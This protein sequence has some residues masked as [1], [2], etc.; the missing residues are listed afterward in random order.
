MANYRDLGI[1]DAT[2]KADVDISGSQ[3]YVV[4]PASVAGGVQR[5]TGASNPGPLGILQNSPS[6]GQEA[7]VRMMGF[8]KAIV[9]ANACTARWGAYLVVAST[10]KL[11][12]LST[13][14]TNN[15]G[16]AIFARFVDT[17]S[18]A[19]NASNYAQVFILPAPVSG[20]FG[21]AAC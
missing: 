3:W 21:Q 4:M 15:G 9:A 7:T 19:A 11:E 6:L 10:G 17:V 2:F 8:S 20:S 18:I 16:C 5:A 12:P 14:S 1:A 13:E